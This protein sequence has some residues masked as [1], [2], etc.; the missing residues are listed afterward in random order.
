MAKQKKA[1]LARVVDVTKP[2]RLEKEDKA[3]YVADIN[4]MAQQ[5]FKLG[6]QTVV[7]PTR[8]RGVMFNGVIDM[9]MGA[10]TG[11]YVILEGTQRTNEF[12]SETNGVI[13]FEEILTESIIQLG[14][15]DY[16]TARTNFNEYIEMMGIPEADLSRPCVDEA[17]ESDIDD[18]MEAFA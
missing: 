5:E 12:E 15:V 11:H 9:A 17:A 1:I 4:V 2:Y 13:R 14:G 10:E 8:S 6:K 16:Q 7:K 3:N 18:D